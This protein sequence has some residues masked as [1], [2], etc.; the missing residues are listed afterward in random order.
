MTGNH[1]DKHVAFLR[2]P[3][4]SFLARRY[5][6]FFVRLQSQAITKRLKRSGSSRLP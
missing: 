6:S 1:R 2:T 4:V 5:I 3:S